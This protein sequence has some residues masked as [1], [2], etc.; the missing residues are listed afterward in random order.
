MKRAPQNLSDESQRLW[1]DTLRLFKLDAHHKKN[2]ESACR[3]WDR[4]IEARE[5]IEKDG[6]YFKDK[7]GQPKPHPAVSVE[8]QSRALFMRLIRELG[9]DLQDPS[10]SRP[11]GQY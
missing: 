4:T 1:R 11:P 2:L 6:A 3:L 8:L 5:A 9:L 10:D 7:N